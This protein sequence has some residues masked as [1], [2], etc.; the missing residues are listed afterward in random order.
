[1][2]APLFLEGDDVEIHTIAYIEDNSAL[3]DGELSNEIVGLTKH[4]DVLE[5]VSMDYESG[6]TLNR[7]DRAI[8]PG[9]IYNLMD[10][11]GNRVWHIN[12]EDLRLRKH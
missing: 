3:P 5:I 11:E 6:W 8:K 1:M 2:T 9:W 4:G 10:N 7:A 12:E